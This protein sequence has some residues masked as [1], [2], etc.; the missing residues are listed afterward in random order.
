MKLDIATLVTFG[1]LLEQAQE[2]IND[3]LHFMPEK[4]ATEELRKLDN[5]WALYQSLLD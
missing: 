3:A 5:L 2:N 4:E 1:D